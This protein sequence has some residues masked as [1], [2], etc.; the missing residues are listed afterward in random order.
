MP[1]SGTDPSKFCEEVSLMSSGTISDGERTANF[2][3]RNNTVPVCGIKGACVQ[4]V[5]DSV[6]QALLAD[7]N[8]KFI[9]VEQA[10]FQ[11]WWRDQNEAAQDSVK[12]LISSGQ[13][14]F[15]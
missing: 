7:K 14:E 12:K 10:F 8:R 1:P 2:V 5:L 15:M 13:P 9:Y 3:S 6:V 4:N 11:R